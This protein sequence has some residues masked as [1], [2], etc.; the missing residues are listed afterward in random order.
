MKNLVLF[1]NSTRNCIQLWFN[2]LINTQKYPHNEFV[3]FDSKHLWLRQ[4]GW[5]FYWN[6]LYWWIYHLVIDVATACFFLVLFQQSKKSGYFMFINTRSEDFFW[7]CG[8]ASDLSSGSKVS[9]LQQQHFEY[10]KNFFQNEEYRYFKTKTIILVI[11]GQSNLKIYK[12][13]TTKIFRD[14]MHLLI[15]SAILCLKSCC[16]LI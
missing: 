2:W 4:V 3:K 10:L 7:Y 12:T 5:Q 16:Y 13:E 14:N 1:L 9:S 8:Y 6:I 11:W 15:A